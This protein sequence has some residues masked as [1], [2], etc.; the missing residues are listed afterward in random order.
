MHIQ[1][2]L[3]D[4]KISNYIFCENAEKKIFLGVLNKYQSETIDICLCQGWIW[5]NSILIRLPE[6]VK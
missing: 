4:K 1:I 3:G 5:G 2:I 6:Q